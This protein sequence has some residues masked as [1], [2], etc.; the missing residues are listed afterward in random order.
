MLVLHGREDYV[1][2]PD[3]PSGKERFFTGRYERVLFDRVGHFP[4]RED[5]A[6]VAREILRF[7]A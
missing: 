1:N 5:P 7:C 6:N 2:H 4:Q 3:T